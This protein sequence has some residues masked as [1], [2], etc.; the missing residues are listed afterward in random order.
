ML[1]R[2]IQMILL[3]EV[4]R[5]KFDTFRFRRENIFNDILTKNILI[6]CLSTFFSLSTISRVPFIFDA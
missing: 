4:N 5:I 2:D 3:L 1:I 6:T